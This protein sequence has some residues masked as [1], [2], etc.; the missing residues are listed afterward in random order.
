MCGCLVQALCFLAPPEQLLVVWLA[1]TNFAGLVVMGYDKSQAESGA[2]RVREMTLW[3]IAF[4]GG[5]FGVLAGKSAFRHKINDLTFM[6][7]V[8]LATGIWLWL[9]TRIVGGR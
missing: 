5:A 1:V 2:W 7:P 8:Y 9:V 3:K 4:L 6:A